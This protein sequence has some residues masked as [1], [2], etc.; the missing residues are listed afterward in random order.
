MT[1]SPV[2]PEVQAAMDELR[3]ALTGGLADSDKYTLIR[4]EQ[5]VDGE[6]AGVAFNLVDARMY[7]LFDDTGRQHSGF[8]E[9]HG[10]E[11]DGLTE[12]ASSLSEFFRTTVVP[13]T[14][15]GMG[16]DGR[17]RTPFAVYQFTLVDRPTKLKY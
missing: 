16:W 4:I 15:L 17:A 10:L 14:P 8:E 3:L 2:S 6:P 13:S 9:P 1:M 5:L 12:L 11:G 7:V